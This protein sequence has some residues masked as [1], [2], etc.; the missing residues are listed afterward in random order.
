MLVKMGEHH[1]LGILYIAN[2][3]L[4]EYAMNV[5]YVGQKDM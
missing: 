2:E 1:D 5:V 3:S 4:R